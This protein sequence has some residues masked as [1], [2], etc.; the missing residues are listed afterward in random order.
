[1]FCN[2]CGAEVPAGAAFCNKCGA[3]VSATTPGGAAAVAVPARQTTS[4]GLSENAAAAIAYITII[5]AIIFLLIEPYNRMR[6]V[7]FHAWQCIS[8]SV[9]WFAVRMVFLFLPWSYGLWFLF[10]LLSLLIF[11]VW[12][13]CLIK[14]SQGQ[15]FK[16][17]LI[18][19]FAEKQAGQ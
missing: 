3:S 11:G 13:L 9:V 19:D 14:A 10:P 17:P 4:T 2:A 8:L 6:L 5:P 7:R 1:M 15:Y 18:G 16:L 12:L